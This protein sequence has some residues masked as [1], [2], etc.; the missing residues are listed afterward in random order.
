MIVNVHYHKQVMIRLIHLNDDSVRNFMTN[1]NPRVLEMGCGCIFYLNFHRHIMIILINFVDGAKVIF[2]RT[3]K[4][5]L[6][7][8]VQEY[9]T[10][11]YSPSIILH[12]VIIVF[13]HL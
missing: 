4:F 6:T 2:L 1:K 10:F 12:L 9:V 13:I 7:H 5:N 8:L 11:P 3:F